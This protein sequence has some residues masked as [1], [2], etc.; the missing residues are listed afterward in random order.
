VVVWK[1][2]RE[3]DLVGR[4]PNVSFFAEQVKARHGNQD[5]VNVHAPE[6]HEEHDLP[7]KED[8]HSQVNELL[9]RST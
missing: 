2:D 8:T 1:E 7:K 5:S 6:V 4:A 9:T 3:A